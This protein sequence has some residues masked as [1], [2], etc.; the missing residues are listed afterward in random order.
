MLP[1]GFYIVKTLTS[2]AMC[3]IMVVLRSSVL[4]KDSKS[5]SD[6]LMIVSLHR[7]NSYGPRSKISKIFQKVMSHCTSKLKE[8]KEFMRKLFS[9]KVKPY[10]LHLNYESFNKS[11]TI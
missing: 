9:H 10:I 8:I 1:R 3:L 11:F 4:L 6:G 2:P 7:S 5:G